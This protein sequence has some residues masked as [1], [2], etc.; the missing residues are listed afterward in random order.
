MFFWKT[1]LEKKFKVLTWSWITFSIA[2]DIGGNKNIDL[3]LQG[4][5]KETFL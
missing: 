3:L 1:N 2:L 5:A 4:R